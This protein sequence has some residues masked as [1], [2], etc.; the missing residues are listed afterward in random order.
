MRIQLRRGILAATVL[1]LAVGAA[2]ALAYSA[3]TGD[4]VVNACAK[5]DNGQLRLDT[6]GGCLPSE[7][8]LYWN[9]TGPQGPPGPSGTSRAD[10]RFFARNLADTNSWLTIVSGVWPSV[11]PNLTHVLTMHLGPGNY[12]ITAEV[13]AGNSAG[14]GVVVC[15]LGN[16]S[17]GFT[18]AQSGVGNAPGFSI[19]Q[20][21]EAQGIFSLPQ[22][23]DL[24]LSC[25]NAPPWNGSQGTPAI[26]F[27]DVQATKVDTFTSTQEP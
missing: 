11:R 9:Q 16:S 8:A 25:F 14:T 21:L 5:S 20:T 2:S 1:A 7:Q 18:V 12:A 6:G 19:Q 23:A 4:G 3:V 17:V 13:I 22:A 26:G 10:E 24:E 15:L 27:A